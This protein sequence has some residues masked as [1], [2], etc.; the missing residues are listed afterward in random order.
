MVYIDCILFTL[1]Y[2]ILFA[3]IFKEELKFQENKDDKKMSSAVKKN[4]FSGNCK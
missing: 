4:C 2:K 3:C 1:L